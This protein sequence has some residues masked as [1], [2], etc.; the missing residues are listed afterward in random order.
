MP[1]ILIANVAICYVA[2]CPQ[3]KRKISDISPNR[4]RR[5]SLPGGGH[6]QFQNSRHFSNRLR[7]V[8]RS[9]PGMDN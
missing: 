9:M 7:I 8:L 2:T 4:K 3:P 5:Q 6:I 1:G